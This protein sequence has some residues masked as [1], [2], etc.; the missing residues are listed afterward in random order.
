MV[1]LVASFVYE[2]FAKKRMLY[3]PGVA[4]AVNCNVALVRPLAGAVFWPLRNFQSTKLESAADT[5]ERETQSIGLPG[6]PLTVKLIVPP[7]ATVVDDTLTAG[8]AAASSLVMV[9]VAWA[10]PIDALV[11]P[12]KLI[13]KVSLDSTAVSPLIVTLMVCVA[14]DGGKVS[15]PLAAT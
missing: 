7:G 12:D 11:A 4:G 6:P 5:A 1:A 13:T 9:P 3:V 10:S 2:L 8:P 14:V 15:V